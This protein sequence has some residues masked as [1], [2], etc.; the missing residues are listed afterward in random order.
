LHLNHKEYSAVNIQE[1]TASEDD[2]SGAFTP[3]PEESIRARAYEIYVHRG[4]KGCHAEGDWLT[5]EAELRELRKT[6]AEVL[7]VTREKSPKL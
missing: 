5:A 2:S 4:S 7:A 6:V 3:I 1:K